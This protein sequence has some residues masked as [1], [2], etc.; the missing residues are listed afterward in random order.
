VYSPATSRH[1]DHCFFRSL[2]HPC[3]HPR[4]SV[5]ITARS[6]FT[7]LLLICFFLF[8]RPVLFKHYFMSDQIPTGLPKN[9]SGLLVHFYRLDA[10]PINQPTV[11]KHSRDKGQETW[12]GENHATTTIS[13][14]SRC[15]SQ[16]S[17]QL[18]IRQHCTQ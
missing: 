2:Q 12:W 6:L 10:L 11:S 8:N 5:S 17:Q 4:S 16:E 13:I 9:L 15:Y 14:I 3:D 7:L 1:T 18:F